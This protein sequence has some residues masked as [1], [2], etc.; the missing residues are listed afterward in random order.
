MTGPA[1]L[2]GDDVIA[3]E[4]E[5]DEAGYAELVPRD[6]PLERGESGTTSRER[7]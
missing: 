4:E 7:R 1:H 2:P 6:G 3:F 5:D